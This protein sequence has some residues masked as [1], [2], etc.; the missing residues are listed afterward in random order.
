MFNFCA[1]KEERFLHKKFDF[2]KLM[3]NQGFESP[4]LYDNY[5]NGLNYSN[6]T[7]ATT[8]LMQLHILE[9]ETDNLIEFFGK[10]KINNLYTVSQLIK[11]NLHP[12]FIESVIICKRIEFLYDYAKSKNLDNSYIEY[13]INLLDSLYKTRTYLAKKIT[14]KT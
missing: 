2:K 11:K 10:K 8:E 5:F 4:Y 9:E 7:K 13:L 14:K 12:E 3:Y 6:F 1:L